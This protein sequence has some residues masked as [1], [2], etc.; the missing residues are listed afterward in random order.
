MTGG[1][2]DTNLLHLPHYETPTFSWVADGPDA[3]R[4]VCRSSRAK[5]WISSS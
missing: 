4:R 3:I 2:G 5:A 1:L